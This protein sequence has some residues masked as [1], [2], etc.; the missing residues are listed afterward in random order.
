[1][2]FG[3]TLSVTSSWLLLVFVFICQSLSFR[4]LLVLYIPDLSKSLTW[5]RGQRQVICRHTTVPSQG[6]LTYAKRHV[7]GHICISKN[8]LRHFCVPHFGISNGHVI[9]PRARQ[10]EPVDDGTIFAFS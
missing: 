3:L 8:S 2:C 4:S 6:M 9:V 1:M 10:V 5:H 7:D